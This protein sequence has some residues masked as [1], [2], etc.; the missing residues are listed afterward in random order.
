MRR[1]WR[2]RSFWTT[3][4]TSCVVSHVSQP[5][6]LLTRSMQVGAVWAPVTRTLHYAWFQTFHFL[7]AHFNIVPSV[8]G[9]FKL[10]L[11][12]RISYLKLVCVSLYPIYTTWHAH[13]ILL[14]LVTLYVLFQG[15]NIFISTLFWNTLNLCSLPNVRDCVSYPHKTGDRIILLFALILKRCVRQS[16]H[17]ETVH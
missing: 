2:W 16:Q 4:C 13:L 1:L 6:S 8:H 12:F 11:T 7:K 5:S 14:H 10:S 9:S 3:G 17:K 15:P